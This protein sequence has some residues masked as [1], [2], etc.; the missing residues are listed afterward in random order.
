[1]K[2]HKLNKIEYEEST[3]GEIQPDEYREYYSHATKRRTRRI[4]IILFLIYGVP[5]ITVIILKLMT[6]Y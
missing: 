4:R 2:W 1:M 5:F 3:G 6:K